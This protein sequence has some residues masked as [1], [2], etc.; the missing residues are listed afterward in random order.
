MKQFLGFLLVAVLASACVQMEEPVAVL[1]EPA[2][3]MHEDKL[4]CDDPGDGMGG[5]GCSVD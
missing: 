5:T 3:V 2:P 1:E 4:A